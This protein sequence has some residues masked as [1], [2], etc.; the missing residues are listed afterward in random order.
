M[1]WLFEKITNISDEE[2]GQIYSCLS[3]SRRAHIDKMKRQDAK[4]RSLAATLL[5]NRLLAEIG[6]SAEL[7]TDE[8]GRPFVNAEGVYI[9]ISHS[10]DAVACAVSCDP[11]GIDIE[12]I[13]PVNRKLAH[14]V[15]SEKELSFVLPEK[16]GGEE[17]SDSAAERFFAVWTAKEAVY[18]KEGGAVKSLRE[19]E[20]LPIDKQTFLKDGYFITIV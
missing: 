9:S 17:L 15:C 4:K 20:T 8:K 12:K 3:D 1:N 16:E 13:R 5:I 18:K 19:I 7:Q 6:C 10:G 11:V 14:Y 2:Y